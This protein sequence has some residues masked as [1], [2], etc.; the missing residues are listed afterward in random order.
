M[1][2]NVREGFQ[3]IGFDWR[4][5][6]VNEAA[7]RQ[8]R[9]EREELLGRTMMEAYPGI[10]ATPL[11]K[12]LERCM[13]GRVAEEFENL[14]EY[15][16]G[17]EGWFELRIEPIAEGLLI[18]SLDIT[19]RKSL[20]AQFRQA[21]KMEAVG[22]L[23][24]GIAHDFNNILTVML[25]FSHF[26]AESL[27]PGTPA[28][29]DIGQVIKAGERAAALVR[30]LLAFSRKQAVEPKVVD[31]NHQ[32]AD[33]EAMLRRLLGEDIECVTSFGA[34]V[35]PVKIDVGAFEQVLMNMVANARDALPKG[36]R[37]TIETSAAQVHDV[38][39]TAQGGV[40]RPGYYTLVTITDNGSGM[41]AE[42]VAHLFEPF[43][44][45]KE[46]HEGTGLGLS[47]CYG[48]VKQAGGHIRVDSEPDRGTSFRIYL[49]RATAAAAEAEGGTEPQVRP[50]G[51]GTI[52]VVEDDPQVRSLAV[53][54]LQRLGYEVIEAKCG[55]DALLLFKA[56][57]GPI[58]VL[59][60]D[61]VMPRMSG[62]ELAA[63]L[64][65]ASPDLRIV[66]VSG[67]AE[68]SPVHRGVL[69][70]GAH[71]IQKPFT[72]EEIGRVVHAVLARDGSHG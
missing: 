59:L 47:T 28:R 38:G 54:S 19:P 63:R 71:L 49:P 65:Q 21:Q 5:L 7:C 24:S 41:D 23:A 31:V 40:A 56:Y 25:S 14:F 20:E 66:Y 18:L 34:D 60:T 42:T 48:I 58:D 35:W 53:R 45:T 6:Y 29:D 36:G 52:L 51:M 10:D 15:P 69:E 72:P 13:R 64:L 32:I 9:R 50:S 62:S 70:P 37:L 39:E 3:I 16:G 46:T 44:T 27:P 68:D 8:G 12:V 55:D 30:Q 43:F 61:M 33:I 2:E 4:Y 26:A 11:F 57:D 1:V 22:R 67:Y 17:E